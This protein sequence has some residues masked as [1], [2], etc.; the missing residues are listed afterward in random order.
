MNVVSVFHT[1]N[2][3]WILP[4]KLHAL[5]SFSD[6]V[7]VLADRSPAAET[8]CRRFARVEVRRW[9][10]SQRV[11]DFGPDGALCEEGR[12]R[13]AAWDWAMQYGPDYVVLGDTDE[14]PTPD[15]TAW[16]AAGPDPVVDVWYADWVNL[17]GSPF[18]HLGGE[19]HAWSWENRQ[20]NKKGM[21]VRV[22]RGRRYTYDPQ[23]TRHTRLEPNP[24]NR[25]RA[26]FTPR[27]RLLTM[28]KLLH[29]KWADLERWRENPQCQIAK[30]QHAAEGAALRRTPP[31]W[32]WIVDADRLLA[33]LP[34]PIA[35][36]GNGTIHASGAEIDAHATVVRFNNWTTDGRL[37]TDVGRRCDLWVTNC[38][39]DI[40][41]R[42]WPGRLLTTFTMAEQPEKVTAWLTAY[43]HLALP[44][45]SWVDAARKIQRCKPSTGLVFV[46]RLLTRTPRPRVRLFGFDSFRTG[47]YWDAGHR[48][49]H[50]TA[51]AQAVAWLESQFPQP[52][53]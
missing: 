1:R 16:L 39:P 28:P 37:A 33:E 32:L 3:A 29:Y 22:E 45:V 38:W 17:Y 21:V 30:Y 24:L 13:Q 18:Q 27:H 44:R 48:H 9:E 46:A 51:E 41:R 10:N 19:D 40:V 14:I 49:D 7:L 12:M 43:P 15:I 20:A 50:S 5:T 42:P 31:E 26:V 8:I 25:Y 34:E 6:Q 47:H 23:Q 35:V 36:V 52:T 11:P 2:D 53:W 4:L